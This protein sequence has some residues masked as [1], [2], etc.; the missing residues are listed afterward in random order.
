MQTQHDESLAETGTVEA[1]VAAPEPSPE[2]VAYRSSPPVQPEPEKPT[3]SGPAPPRSRRHRPGWRKWVLLVV[4]FVVALTAAFFIAQAFS[5]R[6]S[7]V[8]DGAISVG[9]PLSSPAAREESL[10]ASAR[11]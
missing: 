6:K 5:N 9:I 7:G 3:S 2:H 10:P 4:V 8:S 1:S 11:R